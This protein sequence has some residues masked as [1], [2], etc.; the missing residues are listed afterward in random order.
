[1]GDNV[2]EMDFMKSLNT[3]QPTGC[4]NT[5]FVV[6]S[7]FILADLQELETL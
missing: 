6:L 3:P 2:S 4:T 1:M 7:G 5:I